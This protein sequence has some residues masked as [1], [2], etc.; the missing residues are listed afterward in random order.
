M[1]NE[2]TNPQGSYA[3]DFS[4]L[5]G[6]QDTCKFMIILAKKQIG[7]FSVPAWA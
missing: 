4:T 3:N 1:G 5:R 7:T 6:K 2:K